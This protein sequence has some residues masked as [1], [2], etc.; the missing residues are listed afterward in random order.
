MMTSQTLT[1]PLRPIFKRSNTGFK[2]GVYISPDIAV[3]GK[4]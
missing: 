1:I 3:E 2:D 4:I